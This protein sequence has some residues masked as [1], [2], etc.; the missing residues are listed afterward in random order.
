[1]LQEATKDSDGSMNESL[2]SQE[3]VDSAGM[4]VT[5]EE[6]AVVEQDEEKDEDATSASGHKDGTSTGNT[7]MEEDQESDSSVS[8]LECVDNGE[9]DKCTIRNV[10]PEESSSEEDKSSLKSEV[11]GSTD[12]EDGLGE[13]EAPRKSVKM[14]SSVEPNESDAKVETPEDDKAESGEEDEELSSDD[15]NSSE[16]LGASASGPSGPPEP[17]GPPGAQ[18]TTTADHTTSEDGAHTTLAPVPITDHSEPTEQT[19]KA[20][21][22]SSVDTSQ[23]A[24]NSSGKGNTNLGVDGQS[25]GPGSAGH[26]GPSGTI[27]GA[28]R[29]EKDEDKGRDT[30]DGDPPQVE[31]PTGDASLPDATSSEAKGAKGPELDVK[32]SDQSNQNTSQ[33]AGSQGPEEQI[34]TSSDSTTPPG[35]PEESSEA[36]PSPRQEATGGDASLATQTNS[37]PEPASKSDAVSPDLA[38][39]PGG[40]DGEQDSAD[41]TSQTGGSP[42]TTQ[43]K[44]ELATG[45]TLPTEQSDP[46]EQESENKA[47][48]DTPEKEVQSGS[49][50]ES[51]DAKK[52][53]EKHQNDSFP[54]RE[55]VCIDEFGIEIPPYHCDREKVRQQVLHYGP[56]IP[57]PLWKKPKRPV[58]FFGPKRSAP[59]VKFIDRDRYMVG[60]M[61]RRK[62]L[63][64][65]Y[66]DVRRTYKQYIKNAR[67]TNELLYWR[68]KLDG[69]PKDSSKVRFK[70][71]CMLTGR[72]RA[73]YRIIGLTRHKFREYVNKGYVPGI[74]QANW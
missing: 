19:Q 58:G 22:P 73:V 55:Y 2:G 69:L 64:I 68:A 49:G 9:V 62:Y 21:D 29:K 15:E 28:E 48:K 33:A 26:T 13:L 5:E 1:M 50:K 4:K 71:I 7:P 31:Q 56:H 20:S 66:R 39:T 27:A 8:P 72:T 12:D 51:V 45:A 42:P 34:L 53:S 70:N 67:N 6:E 41:G 14:E 44:Q 11:S 23:H 60:R 25:G 52:P 3:D 65:I 74:M 24:G 17:K 47:K 35:T 59:D 46:D 40:A 63:N 61:M 16:G 30:D 37:S 36:Q 43:G 38:S 18:D 32:T 10:T 57:E 54:R